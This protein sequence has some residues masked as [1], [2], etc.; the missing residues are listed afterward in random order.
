LGALALGGAGPSLG[1]SLAFAKA[2]NLNQ[3][4]VPALRTSPLPWTFIAVW[5]STSSS[6]RRTTRDSAVPKAMP[7]FSVHRAPAHVVAAGGAGGE[8][9]SRCRNSIETVEALQT[10]RDLLLAGAERRAVALARVRD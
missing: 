2:M 10:C 8:F 9:I 6:A 7:T 4:T 1:G 3:V 5:G